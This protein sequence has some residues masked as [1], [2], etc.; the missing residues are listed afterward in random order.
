MLLLIGAIGLLFT[1]HKFR[2]PGVPFFSIITVFNRKQKLTD[3]GGT[4]YL[5]FFVVAMLGLLL[6]FGNAGPAAAPAAE[7]APTLAAAESA[8]ESGYWRDN[9]EKMVRARKA[10]FS[11][12]L[13]APEMA[14][15]REKIDNCEDKFRTGAE[16]D[17]RN[18][19]SNSLEN[20]VKACMATA[21]QMCYSW[22]D[23]ANGLEPT[24]ACTQ[25]RASEPGLWRWVK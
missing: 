1:I 20:A 15:V 9:V 21:A 12:L 8:A 17:K 25:L 3:T 19:R 6:R 11:V 5:V 16:N 22:P 14:N 24:P 23:P 13:V 4:V 10:L 18:D 7:T 2:L